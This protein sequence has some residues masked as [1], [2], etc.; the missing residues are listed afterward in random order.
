MLCRW[1]TTKLRPEPASARTALQRSTA[2]KLN[3][4]LPQRFS[5]SP[6][7]PSAF[8]TT[9]TSGLE[10]DWDI[11]IAAHWKPIEGFLEAEYSSVV[12]HRFSVTIDHPLFGEDSATDTLLELQRKQALRSQRRTTPAGRDTQLHRERA[13]ETVRVLV[14]CLREL[15]TTFQPW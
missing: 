8:V 7:A 12:W 3:R 11:C 15:Q 9:A 5:S 4:P 10:S 2:A 14:R 6:K 13:P 1:Y